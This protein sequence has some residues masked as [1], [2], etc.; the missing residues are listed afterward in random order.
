MPDLIAL[1][2]PDRFTIILFEKLKAVNVGIEE[3]ELYEFQY[4]LDNVVPENG[5]WN[6]VELLK[7]GN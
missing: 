3:L 5:G 1:N 4:A 6:T 2:S 7:R